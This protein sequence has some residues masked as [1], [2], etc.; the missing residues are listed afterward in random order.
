MPEIVDSQRE[1]EKNNHL[2]LCYFLA[3]VL[4]GVLFQ[5]NNGGQES[6]SFRKKNSHHLPIFELIDSYEAERRS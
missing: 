3:L 2:I 5:R 4:E 1:R 6:A